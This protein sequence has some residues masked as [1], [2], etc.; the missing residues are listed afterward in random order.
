MGTSSRYGYL[1]LDT[2]DLTAEENRFKTAEQLD[3]EKKA[4]IDE[5]CRGDFWKNSEL[6]AYKIKKE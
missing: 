1:N 2:R 5:M 6:E 4:K 3:A